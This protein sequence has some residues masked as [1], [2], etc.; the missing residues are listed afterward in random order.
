MAS[1]SK[2]ICIY[3]HFDMGNVTQYWFNGRAFSDEFPDAK[4]YSSAKALLLDFKKAEI[5]AM[6]VAG[7]HRGCIIENADDN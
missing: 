2:V 4:Q 5:A 7:K 3:A 6:K 1:G